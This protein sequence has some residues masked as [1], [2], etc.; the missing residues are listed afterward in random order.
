MKNKINLVFFVL[1]SSFLL[2]Q[3]VDKK[4]IVIDAQD[5]GVKYGKDGTILKDISYTIYKK[6]DSLDTKKQYDFI[7]IIDKEGKANSIDSINKLHP[8]FTIVM[9]LTSSNDN[10]KSGYSIY[11]SFDQKE[12]SDS[13]VDNL[14][15]NMSKDYL[16]Y[17]VSMANFKK[18]NLD[19]PS[20]F[21]I[22]GFFDNYPDVIYLTS[23]KGQLEIA[24]A[25]YK[26]LEEFK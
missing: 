5:G 12:L 19:S 20:I 14:Q 18:L 15:K 23:K 13:F 22:L 11:K 8:Y 3:N 6:L 26:S 4:V 2:A 16:C 10:S 1:F 24:Q 9:G 7:Y 25:I 21:F 17:K